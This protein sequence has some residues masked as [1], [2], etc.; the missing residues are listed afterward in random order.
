MWIEE[1]PNGKFKAVERYDDYLTGKTRKVSVTIEKNTA[2]TR[3]EAQTALSEKIK[4]ILQQ[5]P[6][7]KEYTLKEIF[8]LYL[9]LRASELKPTTLQQNEFKNKEILAILKEDTLVNRINAGYIKSYFNSSTKKASTLNLYLKHYK[10][11]IRW[12]YRHDYVSD[13]QYLDKLTPFKE[14]DKNKDIK[15][16]ESGEVAILLSSLKSRL[17][18]NLTQFLVLTGLRFGEAAALTASDIDIKNRVITINKTYNSHQKLV[19]SP[20]TSKSN[21]QIYI[22]DE[23]LDLCKSLKVEALQKKLSGGS[24]LIFPSSEDGHI[25]HTAYYLYLVKYSKQVLHKETTP[26]ML[27][28][29]HAS[30]L[31]EQGL[32]IESISHRLGHENS[33]ITMNTY[34]HITAKLTKKEHEKIKEIKII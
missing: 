8:D 17:W 31:L 12:A 13:I 24:N 25:T 22:Q 18:R 19:G 20:K 4:R 23:L 10:T 29:T 28:H 9:Q 7:K 32:D 1:L 16:L 30:L 33:T 26:H 11:V 6:V 27:R 3:K 15:Y 34:L 2:R 14:E 21:R 5:S